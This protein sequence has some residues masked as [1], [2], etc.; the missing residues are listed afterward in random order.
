[1]K[2]VIIAGDWDENGAGAIE[3]YRHEVDASNLDWMYGDDERTIVETY[4]GQH[5]ELR[6]AIEQHKLIRGKWEYSHIEDDK[7]FQMS[8][9]LKVNDCMRVV[10]A[11]FLHEIEDKITFRKL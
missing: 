7:G 1:M 3:K 2:F 10:R 4:P 9:I 5:P 11:D 6:E 8:F